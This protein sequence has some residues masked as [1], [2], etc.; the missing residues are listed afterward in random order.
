MMAQE[1]LN[2]TDSTAHHH[3]ENSMTL[4]LLLKE[5]MSGWLRLDDPGHQQ[6]FAFQIRA[7]TTRIFSVS[8]PRYFRGTVTLDGQDFPCEGELTI[9]LSGPHYWLNF[10]HLALGNAEWKASSTTAATACSPSLI[11]CPMTVYRNQ[12]AIGERKWPIGKA[13]WPFVHRLAAGGRTTGHQQ[14]HGVSSSR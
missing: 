7:F 3:K 5:R 6:P 9:H 1:L 12:Q 2:D 10:S 8:A 13:C 11:T 14:D 4:G